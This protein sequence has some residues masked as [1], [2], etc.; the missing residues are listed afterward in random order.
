MDRYHIAFSYASEQKD[1]VNN[2][3]VKFQKFG[4][5]VFID[6]EHPE[7]FVFNHVPDILKS[8]YDD[9]EVVMLIFLSKDYVKKDFTKYEGHI[10]FERLLTNKKLA[11][12]KLDSSTLPWLPSSF[13]YYDINKYTLDQ[14]CE[15]IYKAIKGCQ[16]TNIEDLFQNT[17]NFLTCNVQKINR[18]FNS[19]TCVIYN[20][21]PYNKNKIKIVLFEDLKRILIYHYINVDSPFP[22]AEIYI[23]DKNIVLEN[24]GFSDT[25]GLVKKYFNENELQ[26]DLSKII[27]NL[28][29]K[30]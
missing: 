27:T 5:K 12:I 1:I 8:I 4:L 9:H 10:A 19:K 11:I 17:N 21:E 14:I 2:V 16:I 29:G 3:A 7:L 18:S 23:S 26:Q 30:T 22:I 24:R 28:L 6:T 13:F 20:M 15:S 25:L